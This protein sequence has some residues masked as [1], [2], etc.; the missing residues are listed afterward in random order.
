MKPSAKNPEEPQVLAFQTERQWRAW[1]DKYHAKSGG[2]WLKIGKR[3]AEGKSVTYEAALEAAICYG[4]IDSQK[5][6]YDQHSWLQR[7]GPRGP[8]S[9]WSKINR[10]KAERLIQS[11]AMK[12]AGLQAVEQAKQNGQWAAAYDAQSTI[13]LP[14]D[15]KREL[16]TRPAAR[17]F[18]EGLN[19][20]NRYAILH[21]IQIAKK[22]ETRARRIRQFVEMLERR[23]KIYP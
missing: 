10:E 6:G 19:S 9:I 21:R 15:L 5:K 18:F 2:V 1:L 23:E 11:G 22:P 20:V 3:A 13:E 14:P 8:R 4:W 7:F 12:A 17:K 16:D